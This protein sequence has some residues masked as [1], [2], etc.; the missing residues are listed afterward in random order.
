MDRH[1]WTCDVCGQLIGH[2]KD[3]WISVVQERGGAQLRLVHHRTAS[4]WAAW[5]GCELPYEE[6]A[7]HLSTILRERSLLREL[8]ECV[9]LDANAHA[10]FRARLISS[11]E[12]VPNPL[13]RELDTVPSMRSS[14]SRRPLRPLTRSRRDHIPAAFRALTRP[15]A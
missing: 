3:G 2:A 11:G 6:A 4:P 13:R 9:G 1:H 7:V 15:R 8:A 12:L 14:S 10:R 5:G